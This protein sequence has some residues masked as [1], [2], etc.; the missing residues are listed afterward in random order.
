MPRFSLLLLLIFLSGPML[1]AQDTAMP[2]RFLTHKV[3]RQETLFSLARKYKVTVAQIKEY[4]PMLDKVG[5]KRRMQLRIPVYPAVVGVAEVKK[6]TPKDSLVSYTVP[7]KATKWRIAYTNGI[8]IAELERLNPKIKE[9]LQAGQ[10]IYLPATTAPP[11]PVVDSLYNYYTVKPKEGYFRIAQKLGV[12]QATLDSL[13]PELPTKGL[14]AGMILRVPQQFTGDLSVEDALLVEKT[15]LWDSLQGPLPPLKLAFLLPFKAH[16]L[17]LDSLEKTKSLLKRRNLHTIALD[18]YS[19]ALLALEQLKTRAPISV[20]TYDTQNN[21]A[22]LQRV[23]QQQDLS[24]NDI[25]IGPLI[26]SN[27]DAVSDAPSLRDVIKV[28][29]LSYRPV[30]PRP[31]VYQSVTPEEELRKRMFS[32]LKTH[33]NP[34]ENI[35][36]VADSLHRDIEGQLTEL[37]PSANLFR[38]EPGGFLL[39]ELV[40]SLLVDTLPNKIILESKN[41]SLIS[42]VSAQL[43]GAI[44]PEREVQLFTTYRGTAYE[45]PNTPIATLAS[46]QFTFPS[47]YRPLYY[48]RSTIDE[49]YK[50]RF[51]RY[52]NKEAKRAYD[53]TMDIVLRYWYNSLSKEPQDIGITAYLESQFDYQE[54]QRGSKTNRATIILQHQDLEV[55]PIKN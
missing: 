52:P 2:E 17:E 23:L 1:Q 14:Q 32:Y 24:Q 16:E 4:N 10:V 30:R 5:L 7:L 45:N 21:K 55:I 51:G 53:V 41:F 31:K 8:S 11:T 19:G 50:A 15:N 6:P 25:V 37:L 54:D 40:D 35:M 3:K 33:L 39:P 28:A 27:F 9:G 22:Q 34:E 47:M 18:F 44:N 42:S 29:P 48:T 26:P 20:E 12:T 36:I 43:S 49:Q 46:L 13:N 38:P